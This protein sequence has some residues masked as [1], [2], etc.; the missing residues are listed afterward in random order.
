MQGYNNFCSAFNNLRDIYDY[1]EPYNVVVETG[2]IGLYRICFDESRKMMKEILEEHGFKE[3]A[4]GSPKTILKTAY[5]AGM[6]HNEQVWLK[7]LSARNNVA[8]A[9]NRKIAIEIVN[10]CKNEFYDMFRELKE[11]IEKWR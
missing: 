1:S 11:E 8:H 2:I 9:Y 10:Q 5:Q 7:A 4:A 3:S 6:I